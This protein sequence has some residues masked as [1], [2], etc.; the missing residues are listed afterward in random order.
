MQGSRTG[1]F[2]FQEGRVVGR[3]QRR[4]RYLERLVML[5][6]VVPLLISSWASE[7][8]QEAG[9]GQ[10]PGRTSW[11]SSEGAGASPAGGWDWSTWDR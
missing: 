11:R 9:L 7:E 10:R 6:C 1:Y 3:Q 2:Y 4:S 8:E 5:S